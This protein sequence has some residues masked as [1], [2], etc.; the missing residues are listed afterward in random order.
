M[1]TKAEVKNF[2]FYIQGMGISQG[3]EE[4]FA[5][6]SDLKVRKESNFLHL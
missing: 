5:R 1:L 6:Y 2:T 4:P 3:V